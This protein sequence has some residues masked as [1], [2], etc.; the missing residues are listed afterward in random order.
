M[1]CLFERATVDV[2]LSRLPIAARHASQ[3][4]A[5]LNVALQMLVWEAYC[6]K[7]E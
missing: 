6:L 4:M 3:E 2:L 7:V 5:N 1:A